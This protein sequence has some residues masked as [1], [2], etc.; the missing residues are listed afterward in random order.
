MISVK[1]CCLCY[2]FSL[3]FSVAGRHVLEFGVSFY[4]WLS[5]VTQA[6]KKISLNSW[7]CCDLAF[8]VHAVVLMY[9]DS[10]LLTCSLLF[11]WTLR[12]DDDFQKIIKLF[13]CF[14]QKSKKL[15]SDCPLKFWS[16]CQISVIHQPKSDFKLDSCRL[17]AT[18]CIWL[19]SD[20]L[21]R[22][23]CR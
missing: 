12:T 14:V 7:I 22:Y 21:M 17:T 1:D 19:V 3:Q 5:L 4:F 8:A 23:S 9:F 6:W 2:L 10:R 13:L 20:M 15:I 18:S 11:Y 16:E